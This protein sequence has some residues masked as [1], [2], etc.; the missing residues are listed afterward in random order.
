[1]IQSICIPSSL[2]LPAELQDYRAID[3]GCSDG[4]ITQELA[5]HIQWLVGN[6]VDDAAIQR[7]A[8]ITQP[9]LA[10]I[11]SDGSQLAVSDT[12]VDMV[13]CA[14]VYEHTEDQTGLI[15]EI[16]RI[17][18]PGGICFFSGPNRL[19]VMEEHYWLPFLSWFP[20]PLANLYM[21]LMKKGREYDIKPM[22]LW[23]VRRLLKDFEQ[24]DYTEKI[25][26]DPQKYAMK[27]TVG[28]FARI[29]PH[30]PS[31]FWPIIQLLIP[32]YNWIL[33]KPE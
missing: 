21:Q 22:F 29:A 11:V 6:D 1:M 19:A 27:A 30:L 16:W 18:R 17:L 2:H 24:H 15:S 5:L 13:I 9:N 31:I 20:Q 3:I 12:S 8:R 28:K 32:N 14:Q 25:L 10:F 26:K 23:Q 7:T 4:R 33:V